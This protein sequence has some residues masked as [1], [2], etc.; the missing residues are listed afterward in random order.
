MTMGGGIY[1]PPDLTDLE[2]DVTS[3]LELVELIEPVTSDL[4]TLAE[5]GGTD[6]SYV[7]HGYTYRDTDVIFN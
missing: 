4:P 7:Q 6:A 5:T 1:N 3:I 2:A